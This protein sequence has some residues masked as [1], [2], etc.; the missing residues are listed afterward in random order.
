MAPVYR[1]IEKIRIQ[2]FRSLQDLTLELLPLNVFVGQNDQGKSNVLRALNRFFNVDYGQGYASAWDED[3]SMLPKVGKRKARQIEITLWIRPPETF[4]SDKLVVWRKAW[5]RDE[6]QAIEDWYHDDRSAFGP[7]SKISA[8]LRSIR[9]D[10][11]PAIRGT[12]YFARLLSDVHDMLERTVEEQIRKGSR[13][14]TGVI[15]ANVKELTKEIRARLDL[16]TEIQLPQNLRELFARLDFRS[17]TPIGTMSLQQRGDGLKAQHIPLIL[18]WL[19][20]QSNKLSAPGKPKTVTLWG[21]EEPE[22]SLEL[23]RCLSLAQQFL[24]SSAEIQTFITTH[25]PAF[26]AV[27]ENEASQRMRLFGVSKAPDG[28]SRIGVVKSDQMEMLD[29]DLGL[30]PHLASRVRELHLELEQVNARIKQL[31]DH[32]KPTIF[33]EGPSDRDLLSEAV[34]LFHPAVAHKIVIRCSDHH[35]GGHGW[36][37]DSLIAWAYSRPSAIAVG[38]YDSDSAGREAY[39]KCGEQLKNERAEKAKRVTLKRPEHLKKAF[40]AGFKIPIAIE[41]LFPEEC[42]DA[43]EKAN[44]LEDRP[45]LIAA[46]DFKKTD[47]SFDEHLEQSVSETHLRQ[48]IRRRVSASCKRQFCKYLSSRSADTKRRFFAP[49]KPTIDEIIQVL[50]ASDTT[51]C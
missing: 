21:Y 26:Y 37:T 42:W 8:F 46:Y 48:V 6:K 15:N 51:G 27:K 23:T 19:A 4:R 50:Q 24:D 18:K 44:W 29:N 7:R 17:K 5:R 33:C 36:V 13:D 40:D 12:D 14:F 20:H 11:V 9:F 45:N 47:C 25:S 41:E 43:A 34:A 31:P 1:L 32:S 28:L 22:N 30:A 10:Y 39:K 2:N 38:V 35:G 16:E 49:L 3:F